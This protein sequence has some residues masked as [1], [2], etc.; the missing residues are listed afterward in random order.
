MHNNVSLSDWLFNHSRA[1]LMTLTSWIAVLAGVL[2]LALAMMS[3]FSILGRWLAGAMGDV[4]GLGWLGAIRGDY[5]IMEMGAAIAI[6]SFLPYCQIRYAHV[7]VDLL[8]ARARSRVRAFLTLVSSLLFAATMALLA[9]RTF[10]GME[11]M[12]R[13]GEMTM[14]RGLPLSWGYAVGAL[15][16]S[17]CCIVSLFNTW[18]SI[19]GL[20]RGFDP[21]SFVPELEE[22]Q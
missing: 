18:D 4:A 5:E 6:F 12:A 15:M 9:W 3:M 22:V 20:Q 13:Y 1:A 7:T 19:R 2:M 10:L 21:A 14:M 16:L 11:E 8:V 17:L